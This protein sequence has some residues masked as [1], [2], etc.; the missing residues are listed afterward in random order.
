MIKVFLI[1][2]RGYTLVEL[3]VAVSLLGLVVAPFL[4]LITTSF[5]FI[6]EAGQKTAATNLA[7]EKMEI[8]KAGGFEEAYNHYILE[9]MNPHLEDNMPRWENFTRKTEVS[10]TCPAG[11]G[12]PGDI[13]VLKVL[14]T[15]SWKQGDREKNV[16]L[17]SKLAR[18]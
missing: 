8:I 17:A 12:L 3:L 9:A 16:L 15:V 5:T 13:E 10:V 14:V 7:L 6:N 11:L 18:R 4:G 2:S 1:N